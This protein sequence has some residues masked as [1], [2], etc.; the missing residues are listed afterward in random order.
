MLGKSKI[1]KKLHLKGRI[2]LASTSCQG[3][4]DKMRKEGLRNEFIQKGE[5]GADLEEPSHRG[6]DVCGFSG[7]RSPVTPV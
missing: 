4:R 6:C 5:D 2:G 1:K 7:V 3:E